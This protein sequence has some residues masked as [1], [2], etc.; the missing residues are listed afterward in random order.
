MI[1]FSYIVLFHDNNS[2]DCVIDSILSQSILGDEII[3]VND[4]SKKEN[5]NI[6][7]RFSDLITIVHSDRKGNRGYNRNFGAKYAKNDYLLFVDGDILFLPNAILAM[8]NSMERGYIGAVGNIICGDKTISQMNLI[9]G[10][11]YLNLVRTELSV[12]NIIKLGLLY[13]KRQQH[14]YDKIAL[15]SVWEYFYSGYCAIKKDVFDD[16]DG[17]ETEFVGWGVEDDEL[18]YRLHLKGALE[19]NNSA[20]AVHAPHMRNLYKCLTSNRINLYRFL[21]KFPSNEI[22]I[23]MI[24][25][26]SV[27][28]QLTL[29]YI[30]KCLLDAETYLY[31]HTHIPNCIYINE[32]TKDYPN[33]YVCFQDKNL[34]LHILELF[35]IALPFRNNNFDIAFCTENIFVYPEAFVATIFTELLRIAKEI[36][37]IKIENSKRILWEKE[38]TNGLV[39]ISTANRIVYTSTKIDDFDIMDC[40]EY[41][42]ISDGIA[43]ILNENFVINENF[44]QTKLFSPQLA[45]YILINLTRK[46]LTEIELNQLMKK[47][48]I[49]ITNC[50]NL[51]IDIQH[52]DIRL[53]DVLYGDIYR[54]HTPIIYVI[55]QNHHIIKDDKWW[56][57]P[58]RENDI[59]YQNT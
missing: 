48:S 25:G 15:N 58:F 55:P 50:Y 19:Y 1:N 43:S 47:Y 24:F 40:G 9:T 38:L 4:H 12:E 45:H 16:I 49:I 22:G 57:Y 46:V 54:L 53:S 18:G 37:I 36:R 32:L 7:H 14:I 27:K 39:H 31:N 26:N 33:G 30:R 5:L 10:T 6:F 56:S 41:Y 44:Y 21:A 8:R 42:Q 51:D 20:Y 28:I 34:D 3:V 29:E 13:D 2:T 52:E 17:F 59:I 11:D 35:G 23:H